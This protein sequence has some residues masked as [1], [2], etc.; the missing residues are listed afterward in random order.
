MLSQF[1]PVYVA[2]IGLSFSAA[3]AA[4]RWSR[5]LKAAGQSDRR[6]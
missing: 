2:L 4:H 3:Y 1:V 6:Q 5:R